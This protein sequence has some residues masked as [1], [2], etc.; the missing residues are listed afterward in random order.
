MQGIT[1]IINSVV[2][3]PG[4][5]VDVEDVWRSGRPKT[6][7]YFIRFKGCEH[8]LEI[9]KLSRIAATTANRERL[10]SDL[11]EVVDGVTFGPLKPVQMRLLNGMVKSAAREE[12]LGV[13]E[14]PEATALYAINRFLEEYVRR[15]IYG[16][17]LRIASL[18]FKQYGA[19]AVDEGYLLISVAQV[20]KFA[21]DNLK[22]SSVNET[23]IASVL[24]NERWSPR[25]KWTCTYTQEE[26]EDAKREC[27]GIIEKKNPGSRDFDGAWYSPED[28][29][30]S[31]RVSPLS[32]HDGSAP[33]VGA[34]GGAR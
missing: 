26:W 25:A 31:E 9:G 13:G 5:R 27:G 2:T 28:W 12:D 32:F 19:C 24:R 34:N 21:K 30:C 17:P 29:T 23:I 3:A 10:V 7:K 14:S 22:F 16:Y 33:V 6:G 18:L 1:T 20:L 15:N 11:S 8:D 4:K